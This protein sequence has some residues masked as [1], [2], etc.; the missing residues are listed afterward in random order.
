MAIQTTIT[1][2]LVGILIG[3][4][5]IIDGAS[6]AQTEPAQADRPTTTQTGNQEQASATEPQRDEEDALLYRLLATPEYLWEGLTY[7]IK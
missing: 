3:L 5:P 2:L 6:F 4:S 7:P 1:T